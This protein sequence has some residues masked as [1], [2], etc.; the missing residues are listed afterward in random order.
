MKW[1]NGEA[2]PEAW[3]GYCIDPPQLS[4]PFLVLTLIRSLNQV[5]LVFFCI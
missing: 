2:D 5:S 4:E 1:L 3:Y